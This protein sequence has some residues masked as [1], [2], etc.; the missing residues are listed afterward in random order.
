M[1]VP[2][3]ALRKPMRP[4]RRSRPLDKDHSRLNIKFLVAHLEAIPEEVK[5]ALAPTVAGAID[6]A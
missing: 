2:A 6:T 5:P 3:P 4:R 1:K